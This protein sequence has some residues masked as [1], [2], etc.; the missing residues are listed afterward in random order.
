[1]YL[2]SC[3]ATIPFFRNGYD[4]QADPEFDVEQEILSC[5]LITAVPAAVASAV[6]VYA[7]TWARITRGE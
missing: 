2:L 4:N 6:V 3:D 7:A 5:T 1:M